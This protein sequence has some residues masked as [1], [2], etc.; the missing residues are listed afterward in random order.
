[1]ICALD[2][3]TYPIPRRF[4]RRRDR[5][6]SELSGTPL[7]KPPGPPCPTTRIR[8]S[9]PIKPRNFR[10][11]PRPTS[12]QLRCPKAGGCIQKRHQTGHRP[13]TPNQ[14]PQ[15]PF[16]ASPGFLLQMPVSAFK[17]PACA[18]NPNGESPWRS[19]RLKAL[20]LEPHGCGSH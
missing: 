20:L 13:R 12:S 3:R 17:Y 14:W 2:P 8:L 6:T 10:L 18:S 1:M 9:C 16:C 7:E 19:G 5:I 15:I 4:N 11:P